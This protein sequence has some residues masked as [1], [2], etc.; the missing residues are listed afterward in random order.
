MKSI[1]AWNFL[2]KLAVLAL[3]GGLGG[4]ASSLFGPSFELPAAPEVQSYTE[5]PLPAST[6]FADAPGGIA[7]TFWSD[8]TIDGRWWEIFGSEE[9]NRLV[10]EALAANPS[11]TSAQMSL[12]QAQESFA[13]GDF[14]WLPTVSFP[15]AQ[16]SVSSQNPFSFSTVGDV[17]ISYSLDLCC[18]AAIGRESSA[19]SLQRQEV[20]LAAS[21]I[22]LTANVVNATI[23]LALLQERLGSTEEILELQH[24]LLEISRRRLEFGDISVLDVASQETQV[25]N[26][27]ASLNTLQ[28]QIAQQRNQLAVYLGRFPSELGEID[29]RLDD[30]VLPADIPLSLPSQLVAQRPDIV[31]AAY[32]LEIAT[33]NVGATVAG[34]LPQ[35]SLSAGFTP[36]DFAWNLTAGIVQAALD[37]GA[38]PHRVAAARAGLEAAAAGYQSTVIAAFADVANVLQNIVYDAQAMALQVESERASRRSLDLAHQQYELGLVPYSTVLQA[39]QSYLNAVTALLQAQAT[40]LGNTVALYVALGGGW[41]NADPQVLFGEAGR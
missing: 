29:I 32:N 30:L 37:L 18:A 3:A 15:S 40:R 36:A 10:E 28:R 12:L 9:L 22:S 1:P 24:E 26:T 23:N 35:L 33:L 17:R 25:F 4:C 38:A 14:S 8:L 11:L 19:V 2:G 5:M 6:A 39:Q 7:Q 16:A 27:Q 21:Y 20:A 13:A 34:M 31:Q 41:W